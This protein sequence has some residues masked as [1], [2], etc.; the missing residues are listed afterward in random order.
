M[1]YEKRIYESRGLMC[2]RRRCERR[3]A[4]MSPL[5]SKRNSTTIF[6][7]KY[8][9]GGERNDHSKQ[10]EE[11]ARGNGGRCGRTGTREGETGRMQF[12]EQ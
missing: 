11:G 5:R 7:T 1:E 4:L 6:G 2:N 9:A 8:I 10:K 3:H 12:Y